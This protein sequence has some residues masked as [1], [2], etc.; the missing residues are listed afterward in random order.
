MLVPGFTAERALH[1]SA[2][3][4]STSW[5]GEPPGAA[6]I[7]AIPSCGQCETICDRCWDC[8]GARHAAVAVGAAGVLADRVICGAG[9][10]VP[11][12]TEWAPTPLFVKT[13]LLTAFGAAG[14]HQRKVMQHVD[15]RI[16]G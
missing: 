12:A 11:T 4:P 10:H 2:I 3:P 8:I 14:S 7:P 5:V 1:Q 16:L 13:G 6:V 15:T 9:R